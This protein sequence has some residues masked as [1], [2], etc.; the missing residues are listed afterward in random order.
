M[1]DRGDKLPVRQL[2]EAGMDS[3]LHCVGC[4]CVLPINAKIGRCAHCGLDIRCSLSMTPQDRH[5]R[6]VQVVAIM[7]LTL[8]CACTVAYLEIGFWKPGSNGASLPTRFRESAIDAT[9]Y[10]FG[11]GLTASLLWVLVSP[12][13]RRCVTLWTTIAMNVMVETFIL[14][15]MFGF[16]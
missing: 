14:L 9:P 1:I 13:A 16:L 2:R 12:V 4:G 10:V 11:T 3:Q 7:Y 5:Q 8:L 15:L 6:R